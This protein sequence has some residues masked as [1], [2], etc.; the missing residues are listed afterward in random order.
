MT[1]LALR[2]IRLQGLIYTAC[3]VMSLMSGVGRTHMFLKPESLAVPQHDVGTILEIY[4][5]SCEDS[6]Y[7]LFGFLVRSG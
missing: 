5:Q 3:L 4:K 6:L 7:L 2:F 1:D